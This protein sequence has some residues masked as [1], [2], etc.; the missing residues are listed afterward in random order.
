MVEKLLMQEELKVE[1]DW[2]YKRVFDSK[3]Y[4]RVQ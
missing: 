4:K 1:K 3:I 2:Q